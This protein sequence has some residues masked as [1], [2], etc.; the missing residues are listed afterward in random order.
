MLSMKM[1]NGKNKEMREFIN[2]LFDDAERDWN[3]TR[4][5]LL[6]EGCSECLSS[7]I[8]N[9]N[10]DSL[11]VRSNNS[12][13]PDFSVIEDGNIYIGDFIA[14]VADIRESTSLFKISYN[15]HHIENG[16]QK[17]FYITSTWLQSIAYTVLEKDGRHAVKLLGDGVLVLF[18]VDSKEISQEILSV[19]KAAKTCINETMVIFNEV[20]GER[21]GVTPLEIGIGISYGKSIIKVIDKF[22][23]EVTGECVW[24]ASKLSKG[25]NLIKLSKNVENFLKNE[26]AYL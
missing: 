21:Y 22:H 10:S 9:T 3:I 8:T 4:E 24:E 5:E 19:Y 12:T 26:N 14:F 18:K 25:R 6:Q 20:L 17:V 2:R 11:K 7:S 13:I 23:T 1:R 16:L 15:D